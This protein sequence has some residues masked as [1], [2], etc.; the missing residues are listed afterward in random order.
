MSS[1]YGLT[2]DEALARVMEVERISDEAERR[3][4]YCKILSNVASLS[5]HNGGEAEWDSPWWD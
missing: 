2:V 5:Y 3:V 4:E 1:R